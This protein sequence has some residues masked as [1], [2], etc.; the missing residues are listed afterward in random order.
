MGRAGVLP[1]EAAAP[2]LGCLAIVGKGDLAHY[3]GGGRIKGSQGWRWEVDAEDAVTLET[4][5]LVLGYSGLLGWDPLFIG[6]LQGPL[7]ACHP[8]CRR[9]GNRGTLLHTTCV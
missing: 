9:M 8:Q 2:L 7:W 6:R 1:Q 4:A 5:C 3:R